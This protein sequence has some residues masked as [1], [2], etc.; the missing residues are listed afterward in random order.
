MCVCVCACV[1]VEEESKGV[2][3]SKLG[4]ASSVFC[5]LEETRADLEHRLG[6]ET[7]LQA[8]QLIQVFIVHVH[9]H[10]KLLNA[11]NASTPS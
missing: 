5:Q 2:E 3:S 8:Y 4:P 7:L 9:V 11:S 10:V 1:C 6:L